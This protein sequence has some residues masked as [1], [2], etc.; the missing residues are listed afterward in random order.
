VSAIETA[1]EIARIAATAGHDKDVIDLLEKKAAL[2]SEQVAALQSENAKLKHKVEDLVQKIESL[3]PKGELHPDAVNFLKLM[4]QR[5][6]LPVS[7]IAATLGMEKGMV[8][9]H[10]E[11]LLEAGMIGWP[12]VMTRG[13]ETPILLLPKGRAYLVEHGHV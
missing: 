4:F 2:L 1:K 12:T 9:Y 3:G 11:K 8:E 13:R 7:Q 10:S 5:G 6:S